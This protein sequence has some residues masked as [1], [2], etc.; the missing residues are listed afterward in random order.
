[1]K[2]IIVAAVL[3][4]LVRATFAQTAYHVEVKGKGSPLLLFP[5][6]GCP[7]DVWN[8]TLMELTKNHECH[9]FTF[10]GFGGVK[11]VD[12]PWLQT[13]KND[14]ETYIVSKKL[15]KASLL[16]HSLGGTLS[17]WLAADHPDFFDKI[18]LVDALPGSAALMI[19][20][21]TGEKIPY[22]N[23]QSKAML[24]MDAEAFSQMNAQSVA[25][26]CRNQ[27]KRSQLTEWFNQADRKTYVYGYIDML[28]LDLREKIAQIKVPVHI[29]AASL[30]NQAMAEKT[31]K[32]QYER[33]PAAQI[34][35]AENAAH[36]VMFD[37]PEWFIR[38]LQHVLQ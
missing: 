38:S 7:G 18:I 33:L 22:D 4:L 28:N 21:Y 25:Y 23:P 10:A 13:V 3:L 31:Y 20:N 19:P 2:K 32:A 35:F 24:A 30:P 34:T 36:F 5:G 17:L 37:Q 16:G 27:Q 1:M 9:V 26:M 8:E 15:Q 14:I 12:S 6:F 29:L 11:P